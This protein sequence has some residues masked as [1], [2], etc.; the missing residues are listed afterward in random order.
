ML[1]IDDL[2]SLIESGSD[3]E[4]FASAAQKSLSVVKLL[5]TSEL[6][7]SIARRSMLEYDLALAYLTRVS[8]RN[9]NRNMADST[10]IR[11]LD[12]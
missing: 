5:V 9:F 12:A 10:I 4:S 3:F 2:E 7:R 11:L 8:I 1:P 6:S